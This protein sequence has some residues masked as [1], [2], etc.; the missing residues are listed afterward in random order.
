MNNI[1]YILYA[2]KS[3]EAKERQ[4][5]S[6]PDQQSECKKLAEIQGLHIT[7]E[8]SESKTA[9]K[10]NKRV[11]FSK[12]LRIL[13]SQEATGILTWKP[14]RLVRNPAEGGVVL[15]MLQDGIIKEIRTPAGEVYTPDSDHL[16]LQLHF[17]MSNQYSRN[18]S[19][20]VKRG[21]NYKVQRGEYFR[22]AP[23]GYENYGDTGKRNIRPHPI[24]GPKVK[25]LFSL[26]A[27]GKYSFGTLKDHAKDIGLKNKS[28]RPLS[29]SQI[30]RIL[31]HPVYIGYFTFNGQRL[32]GMFEQLVPDNLFYKV[33]EVLSTRNRPRIKIKGNLFNGLIR[34]DECGCS[35]TTTY[36]KS[37]GL[38]YHN[39]SKKRGPCKTK[40]LRHEKLLEYVDEYL[41]KIVLDPEIV[42]LSIEL[43]KAKNLYET[44]TLAQKRTMN[45]NEEEIIKS[46]LEKLLDLRVS[47]EITKE[48]YLLKKEALTKDLDHIHA[49]RMDEWDS[50]ENWLEHAEKFLETCL[51]AKNIVLFGTEEEKR[52]LLLFTSS[53]RV[54]RNG[55]LVIT[56]KTP[57]DLVV[58]LPSRTTWL[59]DRDS[60]PNRRDQ[61]PQS[62]H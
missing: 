12:M 3:T 57:Y 30:A 33:Q 60:N 45:H 2:R 61:N 48:E 10:P 31:V 38:T 23:I 34:C 56:P 21:L 11:E 7:H 58:N 15:Q 24:E 52:D 36:V 40:Y 13:D 8:L 50:S 41:N 54:L 19:Q 1:K 46:K 14:D 39:C 49:L 59:G 28:G 32:K 37:R 47:E 43:L 22:M 25:E 26:A 53:N 27:E 62:Y 17:G 44:S 6:I 16:I 9:F 35:I 18:L 55:K 4:V 5:A 42:K 51:D 29:K 20:N